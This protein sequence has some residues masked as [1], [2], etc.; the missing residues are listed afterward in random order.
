VE[1]HEWEDVNDVLNS[2]EVDPGDWKYIKILSAYYEIDGYEG[3][4][5]VLAAL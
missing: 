5:F 1:N 2:F 3:Y 4:A